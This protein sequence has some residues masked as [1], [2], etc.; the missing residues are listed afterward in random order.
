MKCHLLHPNAFQCTAA[1]LLD[2]TTTVH[3]H[4]VRRRITMAA[5]AV[6]V[7]AVPMTAIMSPSTDN[8]HRQWHPTE[9]PTATTKT[10]HRLSTATYF[11][12]GRLWPRTLSRTLGPTPNPML[13][14]ICP[15]CNLGR[16]PRTLHLNMPSTV[17]LSVQSLHW[18][19]NPMGHRPLRTLQRRVGDSEDHTLRSSRIG[20]VHPN[21]NSL[22]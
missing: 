16:V 7:D 5:V 10:H 3:H 11:I 19:R 20:A 15:K 18:G 2:P 13:H 4:R 6:V 17:M 12:T 8:V 1:H 21:W 14:R 9:L 22:S